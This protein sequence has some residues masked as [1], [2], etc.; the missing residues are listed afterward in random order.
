MTCLIDN[1]KV[2]GGNLYGRKD[3]WCQWEQISLSSIED[4]REHGPG[5]PMI[6]IQTTT[7]VF[8]VTASNEQYPLV[9]KFIEQ[10]TNFNLSSSFTHKLNHFL[11]QR[12]LF[13]RCR[14]R[15]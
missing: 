13:G 6:E 14:K 3:A 10:N 1:L 5:R 8:K 4:A 2:E 12:D 15:L 7:S 9:T 11:F